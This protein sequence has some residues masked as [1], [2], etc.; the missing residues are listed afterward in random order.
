M[1][2]KVRN[3][4]IFFL[5]R[6]H[7]FGQTLWAPHVDVYRRSRSWLIKCDLAGIRVEDLAI[8]ARNSTLLI[9]GIR[10]DPLADESWEHYSMEIP[11]SRFERSV[12]LPQ[13]VERARVLTEYR[14]GMLL[15]RVR[16]DEEDR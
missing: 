11:Y 12:T 9:T 6:A 13:N 15:I 2:D 1:R 10:H 3:K 5:S 14:D 16:F 7:D 8:S 4:T